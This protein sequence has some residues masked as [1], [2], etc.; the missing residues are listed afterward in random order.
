[1]RDLSSALGFSPHVGV[2]TWTC[3]WAAAQLPRDIGWQS[4]APA[5]TQVGHRCLTYRST[6]VKECA[7]S[8]YA[9]GMTLLE[10]DQS[11]IMQ[12]CRSQD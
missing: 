4:L 9:V 5:Q 12:P 6:Y 11:S 2:T 7:D 10:P 3:T 8:F 1:M